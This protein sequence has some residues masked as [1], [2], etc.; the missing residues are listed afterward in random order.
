MT[1]PDHRAIKVLAVL[2][3]LG[4]PRDAKRIEM[5]KQAGFEVR[6][7][8]F[9]RPYHRGR[10]PDCE[11]VV[12]GSIE[13]GKFLR[14][15]WR[16]LRAIPTLRR[17][18]RS[19]DRIY[20]SGIDLALLAVLACFP[21]S[22]P[23]AVEIGDIREAQTA[24]GPQGFALRMLD[25]FICGRASLLIVTAEKFHSVYYKQWIG[26][27]TPAVAV[28]E[29]KL[30]KSF[31]DSLPMGVRGKF[32][33]GTPLVSRPMRIGYFGLL[34]CPWT[35][36]VLRELAQNQAERV[37]IVIAGRAL[38]PS[39]L[40]EQVKA[41]RNM[42]YLGEYK[43]PQDL[44]RLYTQVDIVWACYPPIGPRDWNFRWARPNRFY[45]SCFFVR[46]LISREGSCDSADVRKFGIGLCIDDIEP[47]AAASRI[48]AITA[49]DL[50]RWRAAMKEV[51][52]TV[53]S[54]TDEVA[55]LG[56]ALRAIASNRIH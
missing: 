19:A 15:I 8:A 47:Q 25:R 43:S 30:E 11:V 34:R 3:V 2:P 42:L 31:V 48:S 6:A 52:R 49:E 13:H 14:R 40:A 28:L 16:L 4:Q 55:Q 21:R 27:C 1:Q 51:P 36:A 12:L 17:E 26:A 53:Y 54:Y 29:N 10:L 38:A 7:A 45:E 24:P 41:H 18:A 9:E 22:I 20:A 23:L 33:D 46:P 5:L 39:D 44:E 56:D 35:W 37:E 50:V 32:P